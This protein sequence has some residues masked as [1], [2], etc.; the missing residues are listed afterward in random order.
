M[1]PVRFTKIGSALAILLMSGF[2]P[3]CA[4]PAL[5]TTAKAPPLRDCQTTTP[6]DL[7]IWDDAFVCEDQNFI[8]LRR[9]ETLFSLS[10][11]PPSELVKLVTAPE[12]KSTEITF[13]TQ[14]NGRLWL[15]LQSSES[16]PFAIDA[17]SGKVV[18]FGIPGLKIPG[19]HSPGI[20]S[21]VIVR[22]ADAVLL[23]IA[24]GDRETWPRD[25]NRPVYF[26]MSLKSGKVIPFPI[27]WDL[28]YFSSDQ[29][30]AVFAKPRAGNLDRRP[31]Q[32]VDV[33]TG[34]LINEIP[35][36]QKEG[37]VSFNW[38]ETEE[39]KPLTVRRPEAG[40]R[41]HFGG[42]SVNG[43]VL[44]LDLGLDGVHYMSTAKA[45][46]GFVGFRLRREGATNGEPGSLWLVPLKEHEKLEHVGSAVTDFAMLGDGKCVF[47][48]AGDGPK[49]RTSEA[50]FYSHN[51]K[52]TWNVLDGVE[53]LP[54]LDKE[55]DKNYVENK[56]TVRL[57]DGFGAL[58]HG[59]LVLC[60]FSHFRGDL[61]A[62]VIPS[63]GKRLEPMTWRRAL[64]LTSAGERYMTGLF[65]EGNAPDRIWLHNSGRMITGNYIWQSSGSRRERKMQLT[66]VMVQIPANQLSSRKPT[67]PGG[68][69]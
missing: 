38:T 32:A 30:V 16:A 37:S 53:R 23:M 50:F 52:S 1:K 17:H 64:I 27:G 56:M 46:D 35:D 48:T 20:Q 15:F 19:E 65:R 22:H 62:H 26:W 58:E 33:R 10:M 31:L 39:V 6:K 45:K 44:P 66:E 41:D 12:T 8:L 34:T 61:R 24:G 4:Q 60:L 40:D 21:Y 14:S 9:G 11:M 51:K 68:K 69:K 54:D 49:E 2:L 43:L 42:I 7:G 3:A 67:N 13:G 55:L 59:S 36:R 47:V 18:E 63:Q 29:T 25:G 57:I 28:E 5:G